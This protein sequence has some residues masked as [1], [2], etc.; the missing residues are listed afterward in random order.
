MVGTTKHA[1][2]AI[3]QW[4][5]KEVCFGAQ[6]MHTSSHAKANVSSNSYD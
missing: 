2:H 4:R 1:Q 5:R 3:D 6:M